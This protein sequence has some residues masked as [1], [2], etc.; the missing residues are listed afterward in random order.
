MKAEESVYGSRWLAAFAMLFLAMPAFAQHTFKCG[1]TFQ[2][3]PCETQDVQQRFSHTSGTFAVQQVNADTDKECASFA[4]TLH[5]YW[6]R[7]HKGESVDK[8]RAEMD[9]RPVSRYEKSAMRDVLLALKEFKGSSREVRGEFERM[10]MNYKKKNGVPTENE[11]NANAKAQSE[12]SARTNAHSIESQAAAL[13][14]QNRAEEARQRRE[15]Q[16][17]AWARQAASAREAQ[18]R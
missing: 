3:R 18:R 1:S 6:E 2:D 16:M 4:S 14:A 5:P 11:I 8:I 7:V 9:A 15:E 13:E 17:R 12:R 10:C